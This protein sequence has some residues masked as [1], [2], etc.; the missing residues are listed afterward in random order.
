MLL[1]RLFIKMVSRHHLGR[2]KRYL[3]LTHHT[4]MLKCCDVYKNSQSVQL[5]LT[6][7]KD[8]YTS[9]TSKKIFSSW[10]IP[11]N[12]DQ[13]KFH[14]VTQYVLMKITKKRYIYTIPKIYTSNEECVK[15]VCKHT[16]NDLASNRWWILSFT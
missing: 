15:V 14:I 4:Q 1:T 5:L 8:T 11:P 9:A 13:T 12:V 2:S 6:N 3:E 7:C 10:F 16:S